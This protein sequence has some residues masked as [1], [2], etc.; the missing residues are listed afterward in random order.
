MSGR[1]RSAA[2]SARLL[3]ASPSFT[4]FKDGLNKNN[5]AEPFMVSPL[6]LLTPGA[7]R[8]RLEQEVPDQLLIR[9]TQERRART[10]LARL[11]HRVSL[12]QFVDKEEQR[13]ARSPQA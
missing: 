11:L 9:D 12:G 6:E 5:R 10:L 3:E 4:L 2:R 13:Q 7:R 8:L 1:G